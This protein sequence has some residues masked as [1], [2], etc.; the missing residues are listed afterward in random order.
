MTSVVEM[1]LF[2]GDA[3]TDFNNELWK[4]NVI[5]TIWTWLGGSTSINTPIPLSYPPSITNAATCISD[6]GSLWIYGGNSTYTN[7]SGP[8]ADLWN[9]EP[10]TNIWTRISPVG[11][12]GLLYKG[13]I[14]LSGNSI[15]FY[16]GVPDLVQP[17]STAPALF[18]VPY[19]SQ[20]AWQQLVAAG[21]VNATYPGSIGGSCLNCNPGVRVGA[22]TWVV[23]KTF[24][25]LYGGSTSANADSTTAMRYNDVWMV[26][27]ED[28]SLLWY[29]IAGDKGPFSGSSP[30]TPQPLASPSYS[31]VDY[32]TSGFLW[33]YGGLGPSNVIQG[34]MLEFEMATKQWHIKPSNSS[35]LNVQYPAFPRSDGVAHPG[36]L[37]E[38]KLLSGGTHLYILG[39]Y[40]STASVPYEQSRGIWDYDTQ[41][42]SFKY[43]QDVD[44]DILS[45]G[46]TVWE[47]NGSFYFFGGAGLRTNPKLSSYL[48]VANNL[49]FEPTVL[50]GGIMQASNYDASSGLVW[51]GAR[52]YSFGWVNGTTLWMYGGTGITNDTNSQGYLD[53]VW[54]FETTSGKWTF[55][56]GSKVV[57]YSETTDSPGGRIQGQAAANGTHMWYF[58]GAGAAQTPNGQ[59]LTLFTSLWQY[60]I[61]TNKWL[62]LADSSNDDGKFPPYTGEGSNPDVIFP[63]SRANG[64]AVHLNGSFY[65]FGGSG[66]LF[67][68][69]TWADLWEFDL[70]RNMWFF[71]GGS[72]EPGYT[73]SNYDPKKGTP[74][75]VARALFSYLGTSTGMWI[76]GG[77]R[78]APGAM[79]LSDLWF[80]NIRKDEH[81]VITDPCLVDNGGCDYSRTCSN[82]AGSPLCSP[83]PTGT[84]LNGSICTCTRPFLF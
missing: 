11:A 63:A 53:E 15:Y 1:F 62:L 48:Y 28:A 23:S 61:E 76:Y 29:W 64:G 84:H 42:N 51:P 50:G 59:I 27:V 18:K 19:A 10:S 6:S 22:V 4:Y 39:G 52:E 55:V 54:A 8:T 82:F 49:T 67:G 21:S 34:T 80:L 77:H 36:N 16:G 69:R 60:S 41:A 56:S 35:S 14:W 30:G 26:N 73:F 12:P 17:G 47:C 74:T 7:Q 65:L 40:H 81:G 20:G 2:G 43:L 32:N 33:V 5:T 71:L 68:A 58:G 38:A 72:K 70:A 66:L 3:G 45:I 57:N 24:L 25:Y 83:C 37:N 75:P 79:E 9:Y 44:D 13:Q 46:S 31:Y 78:G